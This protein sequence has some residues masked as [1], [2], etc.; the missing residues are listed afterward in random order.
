[1]KTLENDSK[2]NSTS[3]N[4]KKEEEET[5]S[6]IVII[7]NEKEQD[8]NNNDQHQVEDDDEDEKRDHLGEIN[9][10]KKSS[11]CEESTSNNDTDSRSNC[12]LADLISSKDSYSSCSEYYNDY[13]LA[14]DRLY[15]N[16]KWPLQSVWTFWYITNNNAIPWADNMKKIMDVGFVEDFWSVARNWTPT[17]L[18]NHG[19]LA[20]FKQGIRP[21]WE[22]I[23]NKA[24]GSWLHQISTTNQYQNSNQ[25]LF[26][27]WQ[28][29]LL[30]LI[31][32]NLCG[33][34]EGE[35]DKGDEHLC[36]LLAGT[37][38]SHRG[39]FNKLSLWIKQCKE[40]QSILHIGK[41]WK[42]LLGLATN[43]M[44]TYEVNNS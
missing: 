8:N 30:A 40:E 35:S 15:P 31:G 42:S 32:D 41:V 13:V 11:H 33:K 36:D 34:R 37:Y 24:G 10:P 14:I 38:L 12:K 19:D 16:T 2:L 7:K 21:M 25:S 43:L 29:S 4:D 20:F 17:S 3:K 28:D 27:L 18:T 39:K 9:E 26:D 23:E 6:D 5:S 44:I 1:L 22:D